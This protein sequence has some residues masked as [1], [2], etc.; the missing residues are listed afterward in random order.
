MRPFRRLNPGGLP[1]L[2]ASTAPVAQVEA[3]LPRPGS[4]RD[5]GGQL[6]G[7]NQLTGANLAAVIREVTRGHQTRTPP[8]QARSGA[9][10]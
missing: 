5:A 9:R 7:Y 2:T 10:W 4:L 6:G 3:L 1:G 8:A